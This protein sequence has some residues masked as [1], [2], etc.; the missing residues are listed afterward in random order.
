MNQEIEIWKDIPNYEGMYQVSNLGN[1]K[2]FITHNG[3]NTR[4]LKPSITIHGYLYVSVYR[5]L[6]QKKFSVHVLVA[7]AFLG[8]KPNGKLD[9]VVDHKDNNKL[10]N[11]LDNLQI[12]TARENVSKD[13]K[14]KTSLFT[15][16]CW[17]KDRNKWRASIH[18]EGEK[19]ILGYFE[20]EINA[21]NAY[22][23]AKN[24]LLKQ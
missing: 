23:E 10:N 11:R 19:V 12:T 21:A 13:R 5:N 6:K 15:G 14:N 1:V 2:S 8:H 17:K 9:I 16:V 7:M 20:E 4:I 24:K 18:I 3:T 22:Q